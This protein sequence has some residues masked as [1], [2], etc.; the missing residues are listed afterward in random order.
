M[1][2][3][4]NLRNLHPSKSKRQEERLQEIAKCLKRRNLENPAKKIIVITGTNGKTTCARIL[5]NFLKAQN[6]AVGSF[7]SPHLWS[8]TERIRPSTEI[9]L[10]QVLNQIAQQEAKMELNFFEMLFLAALEIFKKKKYETLILEIGIGGRLD[11]VNLIPNHIAIITSISYDHQDLLGETLEQIGR[12]KAGIIQPNQTVICGEKRPPNSILKECELKKSHLFLCEKDFAVK[13]ENDR[14]IFI[15]KEHKINLPELLSHPDTVGSAIMALTILFPNLL[16][17]KNLQTTLKDFL[18]Q[19]RCQIINLGKG[20]LIIDVAHN[21]SAIQHLADKI[22]KIQPDLKNIYALIG[23][24]K[25]RKPEIFKPLCKIV[26]RWFISDLAYSEM[27]TNDELENHLKAYPGKITRL[28]TK[29]SLI[30]RLNRLSNE[31]KE[32]DLFLI[33][34]SFRIVETIKESKI[35]EKV[36]KNPI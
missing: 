15:S 12:E 19:G 7:T 30:N 4:E 34:G 31:L 26:K 10:D 33:A 18:L 20:K 21:Q 8:I 6:I 36:K 13:T 28:V 1:V 35:Y 32:G 14:T 24:K 23:L 9:E 11:I 16:S 5:F 3:A 2:I 29:S 17:E 27:L 25:N 22:K